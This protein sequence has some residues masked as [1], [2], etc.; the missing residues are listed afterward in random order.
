MNTAVLQ[1]PKLVECT[2]YHEFSNIQDILRLL[3]GHGSIK[4]K[5]IGFNG[6][7]VGVV[8]LNTKPT[9]AEI[10]AL[11]VSQNIVIFGLTI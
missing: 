1:L 2:D 11:A 10:E 8:Y 6:R 4:V 7:Y 3:I 9:Q 5:E